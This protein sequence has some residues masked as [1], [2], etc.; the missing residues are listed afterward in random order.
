MYGFDTVCLVL[1]L[2]FETETFPKVS[3]MKGFSKATILKRR[4][5]EGVEF[6]VVTAWESIEAVKQFAGDRVDVANVPAEARAMMAKF[7]EFATHYEVAGFW[8]SQ[9]R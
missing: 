5:D 1:E 3:L 2:L 9:N 4:V 8:P 6:L 7:D